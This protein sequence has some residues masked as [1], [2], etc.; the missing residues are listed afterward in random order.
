[1]RDVHCV[2]VDYQQIA[3]GK[4]ANQIPGFTIDYS[5]FILMKYIIAEALVATP[6]VSNHLSSGTSFPK[7]QSFHVRSL[8]GAS[9]KQPLLVHV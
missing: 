8:F 7:Y 6:L 2:T 3:N 1:M 9:C 5:K 4:I